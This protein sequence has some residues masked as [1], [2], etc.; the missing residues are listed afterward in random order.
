MAGKQGAGCAACLPPLL[1]RASHHPALL[2]LPFAATQV[3]AAVRAGCGVVV[4]SDKG[5]MSELSPPIPP[6]LATGAVHHH[7]IKA[8]ASEQS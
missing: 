5:A 6:L 7:L 8:G 1:A 4:L 2:P 3:E